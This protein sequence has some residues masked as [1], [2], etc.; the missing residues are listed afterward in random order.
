MLTNPFL[1][2]SATALRDYARNRYFENHKL[3]SVT[4]KLHKLY[5]VTWPP[6]VWARSVGL[7][8]VNELDSIKSILMANAGTQTTRKATIWETLATGAEGVATTVQTAR[9]IGNM[10]AGATVEAVKGIM[11]R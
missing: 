3:L 1:P 8:V 4:D 10:A 6:A 2:G 9:M 7:E 5:S 11:K